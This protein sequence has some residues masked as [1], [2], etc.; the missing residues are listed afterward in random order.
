[1]NYNNKRITH[2]PLE[3]FILTVSAGY[4]QPDPVPMVLYAAAFLFVVSALM[5]F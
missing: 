3:Q 1:M 2:L 4:R 5:A